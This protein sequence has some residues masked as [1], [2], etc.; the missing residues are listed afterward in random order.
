MTSKPIPAATVERIRAMWAEGY[1]TKAIARET[2]VSPYYVGKICRDIPKPYEHRGRK[3][4]GI[5][6]QFNHGTT[7]QILD[8]EW[9]EW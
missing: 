2:G 4:F 7:L 5:H 1:V 9:S 8:T 6:S 3:R